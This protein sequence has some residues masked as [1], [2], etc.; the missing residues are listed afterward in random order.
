MKIMKLCILCAS[1]L[2]LNLSAEPPEAG[3]AVFSDNFDERGTFA[4][5]W[6]ANGRIEFRDGRIVFPPGTGMTLKQKLPDDFQ[7]SMKI[8]LGEKNPADKSLGFFFIRIGKFLGYIR[9]DGHTYMT[10]KDK[11]Q[12][13]GH[14]LFRDFK[15]GT[16]IELKLSCIRNGEFSRFTCFINGSF[17]S[18]ISVR[19]LEK[20]PILSFSA[21]N[22]QA[23]IDDFILSKVVSKDSSPNLI[24][25]SSFEH[26]LDGMPEYYNFDT[27]RV[28]SYKRPFEEFLKT[29]SVD[30]TEKRSGKNS[31]KMV[32]DESVTWQQGIFTR[33]TGVIIGSPATFSVY[34]KADRDNFP[35]ILYIWEYV[36]KWSEKKIFVSRE[37]K[38][39][40]F[41]I[42]AAKFAIFRCG[43]A[44]RQPG[45]L[46]VDDLQL[47]LADK[48]SPYRI[49]DNDILFEDAK[50][51]SAVQPR[52]TV[53]R[54]S[55]IPAM[56]GNLD[57][58]IGT[59]VKFP[60]LTFK[61]AKPKNETKVYAVCSGED[62]Y[63]G[64]R[65]HA[66]D[67]FGIRKKPTERDNFG[68]FSQE[69]VEIL[70][71]PGRSGK[72]YFH[73]VAGASGSLTDFGKGRDKSWNGAWQ[74]AV[75]FNKEK[76]SVDYELRFP[77]TIFSG[78]DILGDWGINIA[79]NDSETGEN[80]S[81]QLSSAVNFHQPEQYPS[82]ELPREA[83]KAYL[84][85]V[86][87][88]TRPERDAVT[89]RIVNNTGA[90]LESDGTVFSAGKP[91]GTMR[92]SLRNGSA[93]YSVRLRE[94]LPEN[95]WIVCRLH[96]R[97]G[98]L[99]LDQRIFAE[100][101]SRMSAITRYSRY[102]PKD[103]E[104]VFRIATSLPNAAELK[105]EIRCGDTVRVVP[106]SPRFDVTLPLDKIP[107]GRH[108]ALVRLFNGA[109]TVAAVTVPLVKQTLPE[110]A[111]R[112]NNFAKCLELNG[113]NTFFFMPLLCTQPTPVQSGVRMADWLHDNGFRHCILFFR[114][115][116]GLKKITD[117]LTR[118]KEHGIA[119]VA[120]NENWYR[121]DDEETV[122]K[123]IRQLAAVGSVAAWQ[124]LDEP[125]L[126]YKSEVAKEY[127][128]RMMKRIPD[129]PVYM[130]NTVI[131]IPNRYADYTTDILILDNYLTGDTSG[132]DSIR[133]MVLRPLELL[134]QASRAARNQPCWLWL[135]GNNTHNTYRE[136][137][138][139]EQIAQT[140]GSIV[141]GATGLGYFYGMPKWPGNWDAL[142]QLN[143][144]VI[145][146]NDVILSEEDSAEATLSN[147]RLFW[148]TR[149]SSGFLYVMAVNV[150]SVPHNGVTVTLPAEYRYAGDAE[151]EFE[152]RRIPVTDGMF[153]DSFPA[154]S[155]HIYKIRL[156]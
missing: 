134:H 116:H 83:L 27:G 106:C 80:P 105:A 62:L 129:Y 8:I 2:C 44:F 19:N 113:R 53:P 153:R 104:A 63:L 114:M 67:L 88:A 33:N 143:R 89:L 90:V 155:R 79:R 78:R 72:E 112:I 100:P 109:K 11:G 64:I 110:G 93:D 144:E 81:L 98:K 102:T 39:Y 4:A 18:I 138:R 51:L 121:M 86:E 35:V 71:D 60:P 140:W 28:Y 56:D 22:R 34:L 82:M 91:V 77:L 13:Y 135:E 95:A 76:S 150:D 7:I 125:D 38:R 156:R 65:A 136:P 29:C 133:K 147:K 57:A 120:W 99:L 85:G 141:C 50:K 128:L 108:Q 41:T 59:A 42:P 14:K 23:A 45:T 130:N 124:V 74:S 55:R 15:A 30:S 61:T 111:A 25:N 1:A 115:E 12:K 149:K 24:V 103:R 10:S 36:P 122:R 148:T 31:L 131:G 139:D 46:W 96:D 152:N 68:I 17:H 142:R 146:L 123:E 58:W 119:V 26:L 101:V 70:I 87:K 107:E 69:N 94:A 48:P 75:R 49:S 32:F 151:V 37:W 6:T 126:T 127:M 73:F 145:A 92:I 137:T 118:A 154:L 5:N 54:A 16:P 84:L 43:V 47:E 3:A 97:R 20:T 21:T 40:D 66:K 9:D 117:F 52:V 132:V